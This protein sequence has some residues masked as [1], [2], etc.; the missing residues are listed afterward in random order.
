MQ[1]RCQEGRRRD[2]EKAVSVEAIASVE[3]A[4][5]EKVRIAMAEVAWKS[6][7]GGVGV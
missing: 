1:Q 3:V 7:G 6:K 5:Q 2:T 4:E